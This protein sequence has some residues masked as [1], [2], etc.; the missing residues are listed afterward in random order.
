MGTRRSVNPAVRTAREASTVEALVEDFSPARSMLPARTATGAGQRGCPW[1]ELEDSLPFPVGPTS[2]QAR[3][4]KLLVS[5]VIRF[6]TPTRSRRRASDPRQRACGSGGP[7][8]AP[9]RTAGPSGTRDVVDVDPALG[10]ELLD[11]S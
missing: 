1:G 9:A 6:L 2:A 3:T 4:T 11:V 8:P 10:E 5:N 7:R